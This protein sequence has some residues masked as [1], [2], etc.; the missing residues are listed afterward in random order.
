MPINA[1]KAL[2]LFGQL[3]ANTLRA[4][5]IMGFALISQTATLASAQTAPVATP[6]LPTP[7]A[8][9]LGQTRPETAA[10]ARRNG[11][12]RSHAS[13]LVYLFKTTKVEPRMTHKHDVFLCVHANWEG[14]TH[15]NT[16]A[17]SL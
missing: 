15:V 8:G 14:P 16:L 7:P 11:A 13:M 10:S 2:R 12:K 9:A 4:F 5:A 1:P 6:S 17:L 3:N